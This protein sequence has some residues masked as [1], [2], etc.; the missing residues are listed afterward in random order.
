MKW[1]HQSILTVTN[2]DRNL[3]VGLGKGLVPIEHQGS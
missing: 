2:V 1:K 3:L